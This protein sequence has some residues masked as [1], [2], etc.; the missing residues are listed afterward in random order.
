MRYIISILFII[1]SIFLFGQGPIGKKYDNIRLD[2]ET[3]PSYVIANE[4]DTIGIAFTL[5]DVRKLDKSLE[6]LEYLE[7][8]SGKIDTTLYYYVSLV[9]D[10]EL[11]IELQKNKILNLITQSTI[12]DSMI[13]DLKSKV[14]VLEDI[15]KN[16]DQIVKNKDVIIEEQDK[17]IKKQ[18]FLKTLYLGVGVVIT[19]TLTIFSLR[20]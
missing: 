17:E 16:S 3:F 14:S 13:E 6:L 15:K 19:V 4:S 11:K 9:G 12:K 18:K 20:Q 7:D 5:E 2:R 1:Q 10:L 8:R